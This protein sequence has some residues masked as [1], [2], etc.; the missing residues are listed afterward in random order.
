MTQPVKFQF[1]RQP[2]NE[3]PKAHALHRAANGEFQPRI[4]AAS[5]FGQRSISKL[6]STMSVGLTARTSTEPHWGHT[7]G[8]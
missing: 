5:G 4:L 2:E 8:R 6:S 1:L 7:S 3:G